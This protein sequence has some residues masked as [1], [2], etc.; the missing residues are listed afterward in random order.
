MKEGIRGGAGGKK[1]RK[2]KRG[3]PAE[4]LT[5]RAGGWNA[6]DDKVGG[7]VKKGGLAELEGAVATFVVDVDKFELLVS[8][9]MEC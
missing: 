3:I 8:L 5:N 6:P 7:R 1:K 2:R 4:M 9:K